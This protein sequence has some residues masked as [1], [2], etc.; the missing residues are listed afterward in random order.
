MKMNHV[1]IV[2]IYLHNLMNI[3]VCTS[4]AP[5]VLKCNNKINFLTMYTYQ[6]ITNK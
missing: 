4:M 6:R 3:P 5:Y 1:S 2:L